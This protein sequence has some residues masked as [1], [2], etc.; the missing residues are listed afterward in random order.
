MILDES[1][2]QGISAEGHVPDV[3]TAWEASREGQ[4]SFEHMQASPSRAHQGGRIKA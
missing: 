1:K 3:V 4:K 2:R